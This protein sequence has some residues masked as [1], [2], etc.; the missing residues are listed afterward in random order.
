MAEAVGHVLR[1]LLLQAV[2]GEDEGVALE[3][4]D[5]HQHQRQHRRQRPTRDERA[6]SRRD[7]RAPDERGVDDRH[8]R[9]VERVEREVER[10]RDVP[11][12]LP[13]PQRVVEERLE[14]DH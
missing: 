5:H 4:H 10:V 7:I 3:S 2:V 1:G 13:Q 8:E 9:L 12:L 14:E 11:A 6:K